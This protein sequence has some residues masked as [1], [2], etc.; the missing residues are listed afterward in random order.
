MCAT[1]PSMKSKM[2]ATIM[3]TPAEQE[4][5]G[6]ERHGGA[7]V[8]QDADERRACSG[9]CAS[10]TLAAMMARSGNMHT[11]PMNPVNVIALL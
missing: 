10:A 1:L 3:I 5:L 8:D 11:V 4:V 2:L 7:D 6:A 9:G